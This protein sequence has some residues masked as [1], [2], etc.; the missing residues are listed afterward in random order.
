MDMR[1]NLPSLTGPESLPPHDNE[2]ERKVIVSL[3]GACNLQ[4]ETMEMLDDDCFFNLNHRDVYSCI[5]KIHDRGEFPDLVRVNIELKKSESKVTLKEVAGWSA[6]VQADYDLHPL[7]FM[8]KEYS[9]R[10]KLWVTGKELASKS[11]DMSLDVVDV[12]AGVMNSLE[13]SFDG[14]GCYGLSTLFDSFENMMQGI[15]QRVNMPDGAISGTPTG[16]LHLDSRGGLRGTDLIVVAAETSKGK[17]ALATAMSV[18]AIQSDSKVAFYSM[19][20]DSVQLSARIASMRSGVNSRDILNNRLTPK[21][22]E[23]IREGMMSLK[24]ENLFID[25]TSSS[26]FSSIAMSLRSLVKRF[27]VKGAVVDYLQLLHANDQKLNREQ[28]VAKIARDFKNLAKELGIWIIL[29]SQLNRDSQD[30][31]PSKRRLRDSGQIE[32]AADT[33]LL[34]HRPVNGKRYPAPF[35]DVPTVNTAMIIC[36]KGRNIGTF[37]FV[38]GFKPENT[39][40][41]QLSDLEL[42]YLEKN[43][44][45][46]NSDPFSQ[47][48]EDV[49]F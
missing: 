35:A 38:C 1:N 45:D 46:V 2:L 15:M 17:T 37:S 47:L 8:L 31:I 26:S 29:L 42:K 39:L 33:I 14:V 18:N 11:N 30:G 3:I 6:E 44:A 22:I 25:P 20:M 36:D 21:E 12:H 28:E 10:R 13:R 32:E 19:E 27:G 4:P 49:P 5:R 24:M 43:P 40:F 16:F 7:V 41:Y 34:I 48:E 23:R 9:I